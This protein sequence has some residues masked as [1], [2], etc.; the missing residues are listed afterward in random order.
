MGITL[1]QPGQPDHPIVSAAVFQVVNLWSQI[2]MNLAYLLCHMTR[3]EPETNLEI[4]LA[5]K[6]LSIRHEKLIA[7]ARR[8]LPKADRCLIEATILDFRPSQKI[9]NWFCHGVW[10]QLRNQSDR[11][12]LMNMEDAARY[13]SAIM[14]TTAAGEIADTT[15]DQLNIYAWRERDFFEAVEV[16]KLAHNR[17]G[18]LNWAVGPMQQSYLRDRILETGGI[19]ARYDRLMAKA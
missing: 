13:Y 17:I 11:W 15:L 2:D 12:L 14:L 4:Y 1:G 5:V 3:H 19:R 8:L 16:A 6:S 18:S 7:I 9:R 10:G